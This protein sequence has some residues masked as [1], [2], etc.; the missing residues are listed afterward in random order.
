VE[1]E[2]KGRIKSGEGKGRIKGGKEG[3]TKSG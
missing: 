2:E 3:R 1:G